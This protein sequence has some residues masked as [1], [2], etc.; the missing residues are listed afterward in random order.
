MLSKELSLNKL[1]NMS[2]GSIGNKPVSIKYTTQLTI[3]P[4]VLLGSNPE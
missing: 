1:G 4:Q 3:L 2:L